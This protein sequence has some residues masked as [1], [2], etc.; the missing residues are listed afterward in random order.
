[1]SSSLKLIAGEI[2]KRRQFFR[3]VA[4]LNLKQFAWII[5]VPLPLWA[6]SS[7]KKMHRRV[8]HMP[9]ERNV[10]AKK[11]DRITME[12]QV[13]HFP[14]LSKHPHSGKKTLSHQVRP[15]LPHSSRL[16]STF[17]RGEKLSAMI[18]WVSVTLSAAIGHKHLGRSRIYLIFFKWPKA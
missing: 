16:E 18:N 6:H 5:S 17:E 7:V 9:I 2:G 13:A 4:E 12:L 14:R 8:T 15:S 3:L 11:C 10:M 1:M